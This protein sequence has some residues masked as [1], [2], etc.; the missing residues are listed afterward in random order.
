M[1]IFEIFK[2][3]LQTKATEYIKAEQTELEHVFALLILGSFIGL[4]APPAGLIMRLL[5]HLGPELVLLEE[6][7][8]NDD[9]LFGQMAGLFDI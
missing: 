1:N 3:I 7:A 9:D 8:V 6:R 4:P 2:R 5:P